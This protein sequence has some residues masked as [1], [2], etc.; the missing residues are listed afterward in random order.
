MSC[1]LW[2]LY[3]GS[4]RALSPRNKISSPDQVC[5]STSMTNHNVISSTNH[6]KQCHDNSCIKIQCHCW[7][8]IVTRVRARSK[9][10]QSFLLLI[11]YSLTVFR[12][13]ILLRRPRAWAQGLRRRIILFAKRV[14]C[15]LTAQPINPFPDHAI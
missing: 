10:K 11:L 7:S 4:Y 1:I 3:K 5:L 8:G 13:V 6:D 15:V 9:L 12:L 14:T 2:P